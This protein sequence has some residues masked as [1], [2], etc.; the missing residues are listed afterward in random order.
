MIPDTFLLSEHKGI[1]HF[2]AKFLFQ[3]YY[4]D[5][6]FTNFYIKCIYTLSK[7]NTPSSPLYCV[8][9]DIRVMMYRC[10]CQICVWLHGPRRF[11]PSHELHWPLNSGCALGMTM[12]G[13]SK[14]HL[15]ICVLHIVYNFCTACCFGNK[16]GVRAPLNIIQVRIFTN[17]DQTLWSGLTHWAGFAVS[18]SSKQLVDSVKKIIS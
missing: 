17:L 5:H 2:T 14:R 7:R 15:P 8:P 11:I 6:F 13:I 12:W 16:T 4:A 18:E 1:L 3:V 9:S 10:P